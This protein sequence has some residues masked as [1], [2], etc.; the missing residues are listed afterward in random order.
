MNPKGLALTA[1]AMLICACILLPA[2]AEP[3][4]KSNH[5]TAGKPTGTTAPQG[6]ES[7]TAPTLDSGTQVGS[8]REE[9]SSD[10]SPETIPE[11]TPE[12]ALPS[13]ETTEPTEPGE[14]TVPTAPSS[15]L[16]KGLDMTYLEYMSLT[17]PQQQA[18]FDKYFA[19]NPL[20]FAAWF[21]KIKQAYDD[22][23]PEIIATGPVDIGDYVD[24]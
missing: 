22:E 21:Q 9:T 24:P 11:T 5:P 16:D 6:G 17:G 20:G 23:T 18:F 10:T 8:G 3:T 7:G 15:P 19:D 1:A 12:S 13:T 2:C 4:G 14:T